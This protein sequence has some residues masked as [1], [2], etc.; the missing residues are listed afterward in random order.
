MTAEPVFVL[1]MGRSGSTLL[2]FLLD[3]HPGLACPPET[4]LPAM[5]GQVAV[6]WSLIEGAP[7]SETRGDTPPVVPPG[8]IA[9][10]RETVDRMTGAY[11]ARRGKRRFADKSLGS[12]RFADLLMQVYPEARFLCLYRYPMDMIASGL[13]ASPWGL[14]GYGFDQYISE[15]PGN[16]VLALARYWLDHAGMIAAVEARYPGRCHRVRY[17]DMVS[18]PEEVA[19]DIYAFL[20]EAPAPGVSQRCFSDEREHHGP[21]DHKIWATSRVS[22]ESVGKGESIPADLIP[23]P[24]LAGINDLAGRLGYFPVDETWGTAGRPAD[25]RVPGSSRYLPA[26][27]DPGPAGPAGPAVAMTPD[28]QLLA[29]RLTD[30]LGR[31]DDRFAARWGSYAADRFLLVSRVP[32]GV[33]AG[34]EACLLI[35]LAARSV[36]WYDEDGEDEEDQDPQWNVLGSPEAWRGVLSGER[37]LYAALR[38][39]EVR[40]CDPGDCGPFAVKARTAMLADLLGL[41][42]WQ[43][44]GTSKGSGTGAGGRPEPVG[45]TP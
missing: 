26:E 20:G 19:Q 2:R 34:S 44:S 45:A 35:D 14:A 6:V 41:N 28:G 25:P 43:R 1:C 7:L 23:P 17:E 31:I 38:H 3:A 22:S 29:D 39:S 33:A 40:Y 8:A 4:N 9:G 42:S 11:L 18:A 36:T 24:V 27:A 13:D 32:A 10:V 15:S 21:G 37:N 30:C 5:C 16:A 12:A